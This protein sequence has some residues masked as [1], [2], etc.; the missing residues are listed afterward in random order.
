MAVRESWCL[1]IAWR[2]SSVSNTDESCVQV[3]LCETSL[4]SCEER[5]LSSEPPPGH[6]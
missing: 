1:A 4:E 3:A 6:G 2:K 5:M